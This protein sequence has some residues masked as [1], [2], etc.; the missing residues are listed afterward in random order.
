MTNTT[1]SNARHSRGGRRKDGTGQG[2]LA[3]TLQHRD[4]QLHLPHCQGAGTRR[5]RR[6]QVS[7]KELRSKYC[8]PLPPSR[9]VI[10]DTAEAPGG[11]PPV[12][13][14]LLYEIA[15]SPTAPPIYVGQSKCSVR[16]RFYSHRFHAGRRS[17]KNKRL[18]AVIR[19][20]AL[21]GDPLF[22]RVRS[23]HP[24]G[25]A[26]DEA[27][28]AAIATARAERGDALLN[29]GP[30]GER[31][32]VGSLVSK[33][34]RERA[35]ATRRL[36]Q[37]TPAARAHQSRVC[38]RR[39]HGPAVYDALLADLLAAGPDTT[40]A[41]LC[42]R[43]ALSDG[44]L[45]AL[46]EGRANRFVVC[47]DLLALARQAWARRMEQRQAE[48]DRVQDLLRVYLQVP[49]GTALTELARAHGLDA[50]SIQQR[51]QRGGHGLPEDLVREVRAR[52]RANRSAWSRR[53]SRPGVDRKWLR[54][55]LTA[56]CRPG[57]RLTLGA[58]A[59][60]LGVT[61]AAISRILGE[62]R[63][64][65]ASRKPISWRLRQACKVR[66]GAAPRAA[67]E[68]ARSAASR[69]DRRDGR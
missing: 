31:A 52:M 15:L 12:G 3:R 49:A 23:V 64:W 24:V 27:E 62:D 14:A 20:H 42:R 22:I 37:R 57:S 35:A 30:G 21:A 51:L 13:F 54:R 53:Q 10:I 28:R 65:P 58:I 47:P 40:A 50:R 43:N 1:S 17:G 18:E 26:T 60:A 4:Q 32:P 48:T 9:Q 63:R 36:R 59:S 45:G 16:E 39:K 8:S 7:V 61:Q 41:E 6:Q 34:V 56:Y 33:E 5:G 67:L 46:L 25:E 66:A 68:R 69:R 2:R 44:A 55:W 29:I 38:C 11:V 19:R